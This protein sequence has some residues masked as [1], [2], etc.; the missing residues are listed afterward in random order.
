MKIGLFV[1]RLMTEKAV[2][3]TTRL[4]MVAAKRG[5]DVWYLDADDFAY[6][7][8]ERI[9]AWVTVVPKRQYKL[10]DSFMNYLQSDKAAV[11][12]I[13]ISDLD[14]L[15]LRNDPAIELGERAWAQSAGIIFGGLAKRHGVIV[16]NDPNALAGAL[17]KTYLQL[18]PE[19]I[20]PRTIITRDRNEIKAFVKDVGGKAVLKHLQGSGGRSLFLV[21]PENRSNLNQMI[22]ALT[23]DGYV[24][25]QE[26]LPAAA[27]GSIRLFLMNGEPLRYK[28]KYAAFQ[29][30][31]KSDEMHMNIHAP[32]A[33]AKV[34]LTRDH[35]RIAEAV[36][37]RLVQDGMFLTGLQ[38]VENKLI[39][40]DVFSPGGL[41][42]AQ[43]FEKVNFTEA[44]II[45]IERKVSYMEYYD[46]HFDNVDMA[47]L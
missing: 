2:F 6:D 1:N 10:A 30:V 29:W 28:G 44:V 45:A 36:R 20:R 16:L 18:L 32:G 19:E 38:I 7:A 27:K 9:R 43:T 8:D 46:R 22:E 21:T 26:Y 14:V 37:P 33:T 12:R 4:A 34:E 47:T 17:D 13:S 40:M 25:A 31:R 41:G 35:F 24:L 3:T 23:R 11:E 39:D 5:H 42:N 15:L